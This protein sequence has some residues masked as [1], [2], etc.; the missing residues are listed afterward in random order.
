MGGHQ[1]GEKKKRRR[2]RGVGPSRAFWGDINKDSPRKKP[3]IFYPGC[4]VCEGPIYKK[5][6][7]FVK[8]KGFVRHCRRWKTTRAKRE[9]NGGG[10]G[11]G[12]FISNNRQLGKGGKKFKG[13][14]PVCAETEWKKPNHFQKGRGNILP[15]TLIGRQGP[16]HQLL[17]V[18]GVN[19][20]E[21]GRAK[22]RGFR[23]PIQRGT[24]KGV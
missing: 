14:S 6:S 2:G 12:D 22:N 4:P 13:W 3:T 8:E 18:V 15:L 23:G 10:G 24:N 1:P 11:G 9:L 20:L 5:R 7:R 21:G 16:R 19:H 17:E